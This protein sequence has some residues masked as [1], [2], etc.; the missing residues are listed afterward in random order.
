MNFIKQYF[1]ALCAVATFRRYTDFYRKIE[2]AYSIL[3]WGCFIV[4]VF[5]LLKLF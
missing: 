4:L 3:W 5:S 2:I 1:K